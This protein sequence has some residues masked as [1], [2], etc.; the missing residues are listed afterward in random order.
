MGP[1]MA[2]LAASFASLSRVLSVS[3]AVATVGAI[4][5]SA[6]QV[7]MPEALFIP[8]RHGYVDCLT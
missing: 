8:E 7:V 2:S 5:A 3:L 6:G 1:T 4:K